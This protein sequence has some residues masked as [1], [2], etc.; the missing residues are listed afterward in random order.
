M[1]DVTK[2]YIM[3]IEKILKEK[4]D[5]DNP[6]SLEKI[7]D[8]LTM[9]YFGH[10]CLTAAKRKAMKEGRTKDMPKYDEV[11][12]K[13]VKRNLELLMSRDEPI[14]AVE[15]D[16]IDKRTGEPHIAGYYYDHSNRNELSDGE[17]RFMIDMVLSTK[18]ISETQAFDLVEKIE[19]G[20]N[21]DF[22]LR[23]RTKKGFFKMHGKERAKN[24]AFFGVI[25]DLDRAISKGKKVSFKYTEY[26]A[27]KHN[28]RKKNAAGTERV[29]ICSPYQM[30]M[31]EG[32]YYLMQL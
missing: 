28:V 29:Y 8:E 3:E 4:T 22:K 30:V 32:K 12:R 13:T 23:N 7:R 2:S 9:F 15:S 1:P 26:N 11:D 14:V 25:E 21:E 31:N 20:A 10:H 24:S 16:R 5:Y 17:R 6:M 27:E 19:S 18:Y